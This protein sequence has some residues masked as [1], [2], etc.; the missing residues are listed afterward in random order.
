MK[1]M[2]LTMVEQ[3]GL[4]RNPRREHT[5]RPILAYSLDH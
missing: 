4:L 1:G 5:G 3:V 2:I